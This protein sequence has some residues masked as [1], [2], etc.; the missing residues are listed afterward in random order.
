MSSFK[1][2]LLAVAALLL[3]GTG[4]FAQNTLKAVLKDS[5][6]GEPVGFAT[7]S[8]T[9]EKAGKPDKYVLSDADGKVEISGVRSGTYI[10][11]A[12]LLGY[13]A[14]EKKIKMPDDRE[15]GE[16]KMDPDREQ[17]EAASVSA[18]GNPILVKK[19][20]IEYNANSFKTTDNDVLEDLLKKLPGFDV[21]EDGSITINGKTVNK[22]TI[23][24][25][26]FFLDDPQL[27]SKNIPAKVISKLKVIDKKSEQAEF[28]GIDDGEEETVIDLSVRPGMMNGAFGNVSAG[29]GHDIKPA[30]QYPEGKDWKN[31]GWRYQGAAFTGK[32]TE[33]TQISIIANANNTNNRG[34]ND[35]SGNM[36]G[37][38]RGG[39]GGFGGGNGGWGGNNGITTSW[40]GGANVASN[41][42]DNKMDISGNYLYNN[43]QK[44]IEEQSSRTT[45]LSDYNQI[46]NS[47]GFNDTRSWGHRFGMRLDHKFSENTS[48]LFQPQVNFGGGSFLQQSDYSTDY[49]RS[50]VLEKINKGDSD[51][52]GEN[53]NVNVSGFGLLRQRLGKPGRTLTV[54]GRYSFSNNKLNSLNRS[55]VFSDYGADASWQDHQVTDQTIDQKSNSQSVFGR[56]TYTEPLGEGFFVEAN[57]GYRWSRS[58]SEKKTYDN[59]NGGEYD[60]YYSNS[61]INDSR[62]HDI[63]GNFLYQTDKFRAQLGFSAIPT[64]THNETYR[65][66][67]QLDPYDDTRWRFAPT[68]MLWWEMG[69]NAN[70]RM[71]YRGSSNQPSV[72]QLIPVPDNT[73]PLRISFGNPYLAPYFSH[74]LFGDYRF[75]NK[76]TFTSVNVRF[77][78][79]YVQ[80]AITSATWYGTNGAAYSMPFNGHDSFSFGA[81][82]FANIPLGQ[83]GFS[84]SEMARANYSTNASFIGGDDVTA[85]ID[86]YYDAQTG[87]MQYKEFMEAY[88]RGDFKFQENVIRTVSATERLRV[89]YRKDN[90]ELALSGRTRVNKSWYTIS[91]KE[92]NPTFNNQ[93]RASV[94]WTWDS[95]GLTFKSEYNYNWYNGYESSLNYRP[96]HILNA[97]IQKLLFKKKVTLALKGYDI[98]GQAKNVSVSDSSNYHSEVYNNT[99]GRYIILSLTYR[100]GNFDRSKMRGPGGHGGPGGPGRR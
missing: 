39:G 45:Y 53:R 66:G 68:G 25:K 78:G 56:V 43:T 74:N 10:L 62:R 18:V 73:N 60:P 50:G 65:A 86:N 21:S 8:L 91:E 72:S 77:N 41:L 54:M 85:L 14:F 12:E 33:K 3:L 80:D 26:T 97:E 76:K 95:P 51:N 35:L 88:E 42:F 13:K 7:V 27:A 31:D 24:G 52:S 75:N 22:I 29:G 96:E 28:T 23:G 32:F 67:Q 20:T 92:V 1:R 100:F 30:S 5:S 49:D 64:T 37:N 87:D 82:L 46:Y 16:V 17:L 99:L 79:S 38:M 36:M 4:A 2:Y 34:F 90:I 48:V 63:G 58:T 11:K 19:D 94:N 15:M 6:S 55:N 84:I 71:F 93:V 81:N 40:M 9:R 59:T 44:Y 89:T 70:M 57:Y 61:V 98:L 69:E 47:D 83:S